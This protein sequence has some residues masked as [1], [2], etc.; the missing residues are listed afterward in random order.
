MRCVKNS[1]V[2]AALLVLCGT[3]AAAETVRPESTLSADQRIAIVESWYVTNNYDLLADDLD[4]RHAPGFFGGETLSTKTQVRDQ[5]VPFYFES[6][7]NISVEIDR[8]EASPQS[9]F[10]FG[11][12]LLTPRNTETVHRAPFV[13]VWTVNA[14]GQLDSLVQYA[15]TLLIT[16]ALSDA[17]VLANRE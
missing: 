4:W 10:S 13:H 8:I 15:D 14:D 3:P 11:T 17:R 12:Y 5:L 7:A 9:V 6:F 16:L 2:A 1:I